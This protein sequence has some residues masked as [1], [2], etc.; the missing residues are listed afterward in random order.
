M[1][2]WEQFTKGCVLLRPVYDTYGLLQV[3]YEL[4]MK[5][6][7][8]GQSYNNLWHVQKWPPLSRIN[9]GFC[10]LWRVIYGY[11]RV[12]YGCLRLTT[13]W[14]FV[15]LVRKI[16]VCY[17]GIRVKYVLSHTIYLCWIKITI[18]QSSTSEYE[19]RYSVLTMATCYNYPCFFVWFV[20][21]NITRMT[22]SLI[23]NIDLLST[24]ILAI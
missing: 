20:R 13:I 19:L 16:S 10:K 12:I 8:R 6:S 1:D 23:L 5:K 2:S 21:L 15:W 11:Q 18:T 7:F 3:I 22:C 24:C 4:F 14:Q 9:T 17:V